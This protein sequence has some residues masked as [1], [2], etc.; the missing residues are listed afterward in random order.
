[1]P[2]DL[3]LLVQRGSDGL[4][5]LT[6]AAG[7]LPGAGALTPHVPR[8]SLT[9]GIDRMRGEA[10]A[11]LLGSDELEAMSAEAARAVAGAAGGEWFEFSLDVAVRADGGGPVI[12]EVN[13]KPFPFDEPEI[14]DL[15]ARRLLDYSL[16][17]PR[18]QPAV[19]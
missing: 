2:F 1:R 13:A 11:P 7:R 6:G 18:P 15:A 5:A 8:G 4:F 16:S 3:R 10:S 9:I 19:N 12:L 14:R 17:S